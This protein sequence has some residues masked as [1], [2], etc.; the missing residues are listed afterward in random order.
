MQ[1]I[2]SNKQQEQDL[3]VMDIKIG[4]LVKNRIS[5]QDVVTHSQQVKKKDKKHN[6]QSMLLDGAAPTGVGGF[7]K[8]NREMVEVHV[9]LS[10]SLQSLLG[11]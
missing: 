7:T 11:Y 8:A 5:L 1:A 2:R 4:L 3:S 6:R 9:L 10:L